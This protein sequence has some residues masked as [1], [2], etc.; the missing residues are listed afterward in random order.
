MSEK[1]S[2]VD[3]PSNG[4]SVFPRFCMMAGNTALP[5]VFSGEKKN[6]VIQAHI[7]NTL[8]HTVITDKNKETN[9]N[10]RKSVSRL[11]KTHSLLLKRPIIADILYKLLK[12]CCM[13][14]TNP[15]FKYKLAEFGILPHARRWG[16]DVIWYPYI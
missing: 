5:L 11:T 1:I 4:W 13:F 3:L 9:K 7:P 6:F 10:P 8:Q 14:P 12:S 16:I 2:R 15:T